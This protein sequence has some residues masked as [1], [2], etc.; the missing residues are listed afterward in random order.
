MIKIFSYRFS[1]N[2][3]PIKF[4]SIVLNTHDKNKSV[5]SHKMDNPQDI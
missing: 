5:M 1:L 2:L 4:N 3:N